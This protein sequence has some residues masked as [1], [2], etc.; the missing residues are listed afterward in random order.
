MEE[1]EKQYRYDGVRRVK[2]TILIDPKVLKRS[3]AK[4]K[5]SQH[6]TLSGII[7]HLL[8][9]FVAEKKAQ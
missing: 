4:A 8:S 7:E 5:K 1:Q 2:S 9:E 6:K 3:K